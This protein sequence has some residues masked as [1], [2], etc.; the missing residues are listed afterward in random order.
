MKT[1]TIIPILFAFILLTSCSSKSDPASTEPA[2]NTTDQSGV[3]IVEV[4]FNQSVNIDQSL[5]IL[6]SNVPVDSRCPEG[7]DCVW[8]GD[9]EVSLKLITP[10]A[11]EY[12][13]L[14]TS[15]K[16][17]NIYF[18]KYH[19][20]LLDLNP[21][22]VVDEVIDPKDYKVKLKVTHG[23]FENDI[24]MISFDQRDIIDRDQLDLKNLQIS[25]DS[26]KAE[27]SYSGG[28]KEHKIQLYAFK[29]IME[30]QPP[31]MRVEFS[32]N[33]NGDLC[34][35]YL[36]KESSF[37]LQPLIDFLNESSITEIILNIYSPTS[38][39]VIEKLYFSLN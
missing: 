26:L 15:L 9:G 33:A 24:V 14:H 20:E 22:P 35:A 21:Y 25:N 17:R 29:E 38:G 11:Q 8:M 18:E 10:S 39:E 4:F 34:E 19:I 30:S 13:K 3:Q 16:P 36:T 12:V 5:T 7:A 1:N 23:L 28:C 37:G 32:H 27:V 31:Q 2:K 6:F